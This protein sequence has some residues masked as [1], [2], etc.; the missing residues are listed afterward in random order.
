MFK[1]N[2]RARWL[3]KKNVFKPKRCLTACFVLVLQLPAGDKL[4]HLATCQRLW[5]THVDLVNKK[6]KKEKKKDFKQLCC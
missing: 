2:K 6:I 1:F 5:N 3:I 4:T